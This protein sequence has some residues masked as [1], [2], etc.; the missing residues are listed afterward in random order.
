MFTIVIIK[1]LIFKVIVNRL[2]IWA[3]MMCC[4]NVYCGGWYIYPHAYYLL[5]PKAVDAMS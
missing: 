1:E 4:F 2:V 5:N 3:L